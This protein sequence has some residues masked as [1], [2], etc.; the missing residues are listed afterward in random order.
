[1]K[2]TLTKEEAKE[3]LAK[4]F[5]EL[6][7]PNGMRVVSVDWAPYSSDVTVILEKDEPPS[8]MAPYSLPTEEPL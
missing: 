6:L 1:M 4:T 5:Q 3:Y 2:I 7:P 8:P